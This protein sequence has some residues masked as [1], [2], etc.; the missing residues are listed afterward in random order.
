ME[1]VEIM[2]IEV[3]ENRADHS[4]KTFPDIIIESNMIISK[5]Q[6]NFEALPDNKKIFFMLIAKCPMIA[7]ELGAEQGDIILKRGSG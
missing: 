7:K 3:D 5:G 4:S 1:G 2:N 6:R